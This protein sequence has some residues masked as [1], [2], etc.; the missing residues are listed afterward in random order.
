MYIIRINGLCLLSIILVIAV[1]ISSCK[2][3]DKD[4]VVKAKDILQD[5]NTLRTTAPIVIYKTT[6]NFSDFVPVIMNKEKTVIVS[7]PDRMDISE[8]NKPTALIN[9]Y[10]LDNRGINENVAFLKLTYEAYKNLDKNPTREELI[11]LIQEKYPLSEMYFCGNRSSYQD[12]IPE[13]NALIEKGF[14]TCKKAD[15]IPL[16]MELKVE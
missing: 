1:T 12:L 9:G 15:I 13:L 16:S 5:N 6:R 3:K 10:L 4:M 8:V 11:N 7:Y 14:P 2:T